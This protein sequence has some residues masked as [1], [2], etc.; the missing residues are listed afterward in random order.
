MS[1]DIETRKRRAAY[2]SAHRGTKELDHLVGRYADAHLAAM[3]EDD[4][5]RFEAFLAIADPEIQKWLLAPS[6]PQGTDFAELVADIRRFHGL[7]D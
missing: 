4:L 3:G 5:T 2:R 7:T 6:M 1:T